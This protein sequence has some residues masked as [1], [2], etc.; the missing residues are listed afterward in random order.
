MISLS[1]RGPGTSKAFSW[2]FLS[3]DFRRFYSF[4]FQIILTGRSVFQVRFKILLFFASFLG[5]KAV[6]SI[7]FFRSILASVQFWIINLI[8]LYRTLKPKIFHCSFPFLSSTTCSSNDSNNVLIGFPCQV[9]SV[10]LL[11]NLVRQPF[12]DHFLQIWAGNHSLIVKSLDFGKH[13]SYA[14]PISDTFKVCVCFVP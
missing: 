14:T 3:F 9:H 11:N 13:I 2:C 12:E 1:V 7:G 6:S 10:R 4:G 8:P 5:S